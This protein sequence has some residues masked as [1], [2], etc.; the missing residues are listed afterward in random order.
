MS[1]D[2]ICSLHELNVARCLFQPF[3]PSLWH[4]VCLRQRLQHQP[5]VALDAVKVTSTWLGCSF[6]CLHDKAM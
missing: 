6:K 5:F 2:L 3:W 4:Q 1:S